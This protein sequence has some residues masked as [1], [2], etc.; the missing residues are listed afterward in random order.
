MH[1]H[2]ILGRIPED[3][4]RL[5]W[6]DEWYELGGISRIYPYEVNKGAEFYMS[7]SVYAW[8]NGE[9]DISGN[10]PVNPLAL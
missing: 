8:K 4:K 1:F 10:L 3:V 5:F 7:K 6:M 9:I 2:A